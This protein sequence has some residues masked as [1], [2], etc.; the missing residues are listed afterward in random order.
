QAVLRES[1]TL[2]SQI[3]AAEAAAPADDPG[4]SLEAAIGATLRLTREHPL[5]DRL[6]RTEP[7]ALLPLLVGDVGPVTG[8]VRSIVEQIVHQRLPELSA[9]ETRRAAD[10]LT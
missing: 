1:A 4:A 2:V 3:V 5:L 10:V 7:E 9:I 8:A 6:V